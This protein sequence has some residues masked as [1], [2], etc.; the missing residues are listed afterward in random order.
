MIYHS[1]P[2]QRCSVPFC[3][4]QHFLQIIIQIV[5][6]A[7]EYRP[8]KVDLE[9]WPES[10]PNP[11]PETGLYLNTVNTHWLRDQLFFTKNRYTNTRKAHENSVHLKL[12]KNPYNF[13]STLFFS[14]NFYFLHCHV[15]QLKKATCKSVFQ[16]KD[17][18]KSK[19]IQTVQVRYRIMCTFFKLV[20]LHVPSYVRLCTDTGI[21]ATNRYCTRKIGTVGHVTHWIIWEKYWTV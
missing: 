8:T 16:S 3:G 4:T 14:N 13:F 18:T 17:L 11:L 15:N 5:F 10:L 2:F 20:Y 21:L 6:R 19:K 7:F 12:T 9:D 1:L